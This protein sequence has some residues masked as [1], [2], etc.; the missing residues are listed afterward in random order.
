[1]PGRG[2]ALAKRIENLL[3]RAGTTFGAGQL[4]GTLTRVT[5]ITGPSYAP[6]GKTTQTYPFTC[7]WGAFEFQERLTGLVE[8]GDHRL[9]IGASSLTVFPRPGD[10]VTISGVT[11][12]VKNVDVVRPGGTPLLY[13][14]IVRI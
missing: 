11:Y 9:L 14:L 3:K 8:D 2:P 7:L 1:M 5:G 10:T 12:N 4:T 13:Q 6:T